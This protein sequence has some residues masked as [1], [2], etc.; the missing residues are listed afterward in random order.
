MRRLRKNF[1]ALFFAVFASANNFPH[2]EASTCNAS[3]QDIMAVSGSSGNGRLNNVDVM[4]IDQDGGIHFS[5]ACTNGVGLDYE[6]FLANGT[7]VSTGNDV[8]LA[9]ASIIFSSAT[10][11][12]ST[13][14]AISGQGLIFPALMLAGSVPTAASIGSVLCSTPSAST[15]ISVWVCPAVLGVSSEIGVAAAA[16]STGSVV[17]VFDTGWVLALGTGTINAGDNLGTSAFSS[18]TFQ[19]NVATNGVT[20]AIALSGLTSGFPGLVRVKLK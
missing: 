18:G 14:T 6:T 5:T 16:A 3:L 12:I 8:F 2:V 19:T 10:A 11:A 9:P 13:S 20:G 17:S 1:A 15:L 7:E 4:R